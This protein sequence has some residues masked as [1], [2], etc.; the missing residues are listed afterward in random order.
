MRILPFMDIPV[1]EV[2][3]PSTEKR[4]EVLDK[5]AENDPIKLSVCFL[6]YINDGN[7]I[8]DYYFQVGF[9]HKGNVV[10][11]AKAIEEIGD[12]FYSIKDGK[13][14]NGLLP[15]LRDH[16]ALYFD[17]IGII[18]KWGVRKF[19]E[20]KAQGRAIRWLEGP[21]KVGKLKPNQRREVILDKRGEI[22]Y[23]PIIR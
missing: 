7:S 11:T 12:S 14:Y 2:R 13:E 15:K 22:V 16:I 8:D 4:R 3:T 1:M 23:G 20:L 9:I 5:W 17:K 10:T 19:Y 21:H 6:S 18:P